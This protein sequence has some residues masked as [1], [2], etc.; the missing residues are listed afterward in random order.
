MAKRKIIKIDEE[1][2]DG[3]GLCIPNCHEGAIRIIDGKARLV[4]DRLC[5][6]LGACLGHCPKEAITIEAREAAEY[7]E[8]VVKKHT[9]GLKTC[10]GSKV[11]NLGPLAKSAPVKTGKADADARRESRL[12]NWPVQIRLV[13]ADAPYFEGAELLIAADCV[14][15][16]HPELHEKLLDGKVL[17][18][19]CPKLDDIGL[20]KEKIAEIVR[21]NKIK[22]ITCAHMEVPCC[23]GLVSAVKEAIEDSGRDVPFEEAVISIKGG[24]I[25]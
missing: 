17:L 13:P 10:P 24:R 5:D 14:G 18:V 15:F 3:C 21:G 9:H 22:S 19:G 23:F 11:L 7:D 16:A 8:K 2:C 1:K 12:S 25:R 20:Y 6:G 4:S